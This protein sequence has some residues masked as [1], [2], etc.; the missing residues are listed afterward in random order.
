MGAADMGIL[1]RALLVKGVVLRLSVVHGQFVRDRPRMGE[2]VAGVEG[3]EAVELLDPVTHVHGDPAH[4]PAF[5]KDQVLFY[6]VIERCQFG[7]V[8]VVLGNGHIVL[9]QLGASP[10]SEPHIP[11]GVGFFS[12][13]SSRTKPLTMYSRKR[14]VAQMRN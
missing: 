2:D 9:P 12:R 4:G 1:L 14:W 10:G 13:S 11:L 6:E 3:K 8:Q 7:L 5:G